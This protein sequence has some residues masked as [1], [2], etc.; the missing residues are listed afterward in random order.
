MANPI[1]KYYLKAQNMQIST[2]LL[3]IQK[4]PLFKLIKNKKIKNVGRQQKISRFL[5][6]QTLAKKRL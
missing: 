3:F 4:R 6:C 2:F 5:L 1:Q